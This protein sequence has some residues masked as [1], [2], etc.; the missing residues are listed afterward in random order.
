[1]DPAE[2]AQA[3]ARQFMTRTA[4]RHPGNAARTLLRDLEL[5]RVNVA[6]LLALLSANAPPKQTGQPSH[7]GT[8]ALSPAS[9]E[10]PVPACCGSRGDARRHTPDLTAR[11]LVEFRRRVL[12]PPAPAARVTISPRRALL[13]VPARIRH[14]RPGRLTLRILAAAVL[15]ALILRSGAGTPPVAG[16]LAGIATWLILTSRGDLAPPP[17]R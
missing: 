14:G 6:A 3:A 8:T 13:M 9:P 2:L 12:P 5:A 11:N 4:G 10:P 16:L 7:P 15:T 17:G 1:M